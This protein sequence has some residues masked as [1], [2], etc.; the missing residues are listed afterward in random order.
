MYLLYD[1]L[2]IAFIIT[3]IIIEPS[4]FL[5]FLEVLPLFGCWPFLILH[6]LDLNTIEI[7]MRV[8]HN[9]IFCNYRSINFTDLVCCDVGLIPSDNRPY[10]IMHFW[11]SVCRAYCT[12]AMKYVNMSCQMS[13]CRTTHFMQWNLWLLLHEIPA[14][15]FLTRTIW[16][17]MLLLW[18]EG[19]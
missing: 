18:N 6:L 15:I 14:I 13:S 5:H 11:H 12:N 19:T 1:D 8:T 4:V 2:S 17:E 9:R 7:I 10:S 16:K 3:F